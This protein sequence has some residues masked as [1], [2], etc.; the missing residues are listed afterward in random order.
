ME[1]KI[2]AF[3]GTVVFAAITMISSCTKTCDLGY[4]GDNCTTEV[5]ESFL[6]NFSGKET[7]GTATDTF[8]IT[9][10]PIS[11]DVTKIKLNNIYNSTLNA[12]GTVMANGAITIE[13]Q[14]FGTGNI[15]GSVTSTGGKISIAY[16]VTVAGTPDATCTWVQN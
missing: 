9:I 15:S 1:K 3:A 2:K 13:P 10:S 7:C 16:I 14:N 5:R 12:I 11:T 8:S 6:G 4:K